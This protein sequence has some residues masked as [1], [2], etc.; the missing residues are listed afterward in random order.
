M[1]LQIGFLIFPNM[2]PLDMVGPYE[3]FGKMPDTE[4]H[5]VWKSLV[6]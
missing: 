1:P 4:V 6:R 2:M 3:V 5:L